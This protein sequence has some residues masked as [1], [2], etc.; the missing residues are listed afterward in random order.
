MKIHY[1]FWQSHVAI[2]HSPFIDGFPIPV[3][4]PLIGDFPASHGLP[5]GRRVDPYQP[6]VHHCMEYHQKAHDTT[7]LATLW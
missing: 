5:Q 4:H 2:E 3:K 7:I 6:I 1:A